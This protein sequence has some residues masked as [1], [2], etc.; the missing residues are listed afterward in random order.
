MKRKIQFILKA[1][2]PSLF[3]LVI[4]LPIFTYWV[5]LDQNQVWYTA[6]LTG[7]IPFAFFIFKGF[8]CFLIQE[9]PS[10]SDMKNLGKFYLHARLNRLF[11]TVIC[12]YLILLIFLLGTYLLLFGIDQ[13]V[14]QFTTIKVVS[15]RNYFW[16]TAIIFPI[17]LNYQ[18]SRFNTG[19]FFQ[20]SQLSISVLIDQEVSK[21]TSWYYWRRKFRF[22]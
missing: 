19:R 6:L 2:L 3:V 9:K 11:W 7:L 21:Y 20:E 17:I 14:L 22:K 12:S 18:F 16:W 10:F 5:G 8:Y 1:L 15:L 4:S 13:I